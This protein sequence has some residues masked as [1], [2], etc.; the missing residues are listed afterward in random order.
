MNNI[1]IRNF[2]DINIIKGK[3][4]TIQSSR[5]I[6]VLL[7]TNDDIDISEPIKF[8]SLQEVYDE[9]AAGMIEA[10]PGQIKATVLYNYAK[11]YFENGGIELLTVYIDPTKLNQDFTVSSDFS[12]TYLNNLN[13]ESIIIALAIETA[14]TYSGLYMNSISNQYYSQLDSNGN[15]LMYGVKRKIFIGSIAYTNDTGYSSQDVA[16]KMIDIS[17]QLGGEMTIA[18]YLNQI[19]FYKQDSVMD[20]CYTLENLDVSTFVELSDINTV[21]KNA[22]SKNMNITIGLGNAQ[23]DENTIGRN[24]GG[25]L[26]NGDDIVNTFSLIVLQQT[27]SQRI[28][29]TLAQKIKGNAG[30]TA[31]YATI[32]QELNKYV[33]DG[34][35][36]TD[37]VYTG[38]DINV[39]DSLGNKY[40]LLEKGTALTAGYIVK[41]L[42]LSSLTQED[43]EQR[44]APLIYIILSDSYGIR[45]IE[46][47]GQAI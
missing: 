6:T 5:P 42:P 40:L 18:A 39:S 10:T 32:S 4:A 11:V 33:Q 45:K 26:V 37:R 17:K 29:N 22:F 27:L 2:V 43:I 30:I 13:D 44:K 41:I 36:T 34:Y 15:K 9:L 12:E 24:I 28:L 31:L 3:T 23:N 47:I 21:I 46:I 35:L 7:T 19:D 38:E 16:F 1:D 8:T 20:Y 14:N 25:N